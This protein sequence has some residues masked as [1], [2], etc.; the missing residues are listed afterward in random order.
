VLHQSSL[1]VP[2]DS[3]VALI[4][5]DLEGVSVEFLEHFVNE[6]G[7]GRM[8]NVLDV[9][10]GMGRMTYALA[11]FLDAS[12]HY[13]GFDIIPSL[14]QW[15]QKNISPV[16]PNF[17]FSEAPIY[18]SFYS[19]GGH[20][21]PTDFIFPYAPATFD[22][23]LLTSVFTHMEGPEIRHY[24]REI[25][26]VLRPG[27]RC[28]I[29]CFLLNSDSRGLIRQGKSALDISV[30]RGDSMIADPKNPEYAVGFD[31]EVLRSWFQSAGL[32]VSKALYGNWCGRERFVSF[33]DMLVVHG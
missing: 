24:L 25:R 30:P 23:A 7:L 4:G 18:N 19:P 14:V 27:G 2:P 9:G 29:T 20:L 32:T 1:P 26:R 11:G 21:K 6:A 22:F 12:A 5:S 16:L 28:L 33:Q 15:A 31:E 17:R 10:C 8:A 3:F 13:E